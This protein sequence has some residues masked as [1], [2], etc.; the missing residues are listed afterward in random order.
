MNV[1][2]VSN[3]KIMKS[4]YKINNE[5]I[6]NILLLGYKQKNE[7]SFIYSVPEKEAYLLLESLGNHK[8]AVTGYVKNEVL[9]D[10][11]EFTLDFEKYPSVERAVNNS[12]IGIAKSNFLHWLY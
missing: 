8:Y 5:E 3:D 1:T 4:V 12:G 10:R 2:Q 7:N 11:K 6:K 9:M